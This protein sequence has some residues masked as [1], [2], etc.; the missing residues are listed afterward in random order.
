MADFKLN[1]VIQTSLENIRKIVDVNTIVG[2]P[3]PVNNG[4]VIIPVSKVAVGFASGG[5]DF[6]GKHS[7]E[8]E[9]ANSF[10]GGGGTGVSVSPVGFLVINAEGDVS[11]LNINNPANL[12]NDIGSN[13][14]SLLDK[15]PEIVKKIKSLLPKKKKGDKDEEAEDEAA[16]TPVPADVNVNEL[17]EN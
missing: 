7:K 16:E 14:V 6:I 2:E 3:I 10:S 8:T 15:T 17:S 13:V 9:R 4:T 5:A 11:M 12:S 1:D